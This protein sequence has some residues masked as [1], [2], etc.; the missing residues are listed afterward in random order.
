MQKRIVKNPPVE[1]ALRL[2]DQ[3]NRQR[4]FAWFGYLE[5]WD[6]DE[7]VRSHSFPL[8]SM[9]DVLVL[10]TTT[11]LRIF[12][13]IQGDTIT[14]IDIAKKQSILASGQLSEAR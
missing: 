9:P 1:V 13:T 12:F 5:N 2:L 7:F 8:E 6:N 11:D 10:Q 14:I 4:V 3:D